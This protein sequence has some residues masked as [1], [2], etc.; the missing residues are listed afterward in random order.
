MSKRKRIF[1]NLQR[2]VYAFERLDDTTNVVT[3]LRII[4]DVV[5]TF[6]GD[7]VGGE[8]PGLGDANPHPGSV[9]TH[10][11]L[12]ESG[13]EVHSADLLTTQGGVLPVTA[14]EGDDVSIERVSKRL[15]SSRSGSLTEEISATSILSEGKF[16]FHQYSRP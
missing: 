16:N 7:A 6:I 8:K 14:T 5:D 15:R 2:I 4:N 3:D 12:L 11:N 1:S 13:C 9:S 10:T